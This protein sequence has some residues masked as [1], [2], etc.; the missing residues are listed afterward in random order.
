KWDQAL[1]TNE[2]FTK[3]MLAAAYTP[4]SNE[5]PGIRNYGYG[6]RMNV[7][8]DGRKIIYHNGW[9]H[10]NNTVFI[11]MIQDSVTIIVLGNK[12]NH[13]IYQAK[14]MTTL[15]EPTSVMEDEEKDPRS[16]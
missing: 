9:W 14:K 13:A 6:W 7:Y 4:Y 5:K 11:R 16:K 1:Y 3:E 2:L 15:F 10:G 8:P 12:F